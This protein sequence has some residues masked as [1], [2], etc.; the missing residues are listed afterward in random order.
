MVKYLCLFTGVLLFACDNNSNS[1]A[2]PTTLPISSQA[3][4]T[5]LIE[6]DTL[7]FSLT[8]QIDSFL[9]HALTGNQHAREFDITKDLPW[10]LEIFSQEG[11]IKI[12]G[13]FDQRYPKRAESTFYEHFVLF[14][15]EYQDTTHAAHAFETFRQEVEKG[16][17]IYEESRKNQQPVDVDH[18]ILNKAGG[19]ICQKGEYVFS[20]V[21]T[22]R[23]TPIG[24]TWKSYEN[25]FITY[26]TEPEETLTVLNANCGGIRY[27]VEKRKG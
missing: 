2:I 3:E 20:L 15:L 5:D 25:V 9:Q 21:E 8:Q 18:R 1:Q 22:C 4:P 6:P 19:M 16:N 13:H 12:E 17:Q 14:T 27:H 23:D 10:Y 7:T 24:G 26:I 11:L